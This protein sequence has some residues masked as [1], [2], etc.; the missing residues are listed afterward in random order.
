MAS[1][2]N[3]TIEFWV[4]L[5]A[6]PSADWRVIVGKGLSSGN[7]YE[8]FFEC[9][10]DN[11]LKFLASDDGTAWPINQSFTDT[12][13]NGTWYH[14]AVVRN[15][16]GAN[17]LKGYLNGVQKWSITSLNLHTSGGGLG[18][19]AHNDGGSITLESNTTV[20]NLRI[21]KGTSVYTSAFTPSTTPLTA[22]SNTKLL[23]C[24]SGDSTVYDVSPGAISSSGH[25]Y[26]DYGESPFTKKKFQ[27]DGIGYTSASA[28]GLTAGSTTPTGC[29]IGTKQGFSIVR[30]TLGTNSGTITIPHGLGKTPEFIIAKSLKNN[31]YNWDIYHK[32]ATPSGQNRLIFTASQLDSNDPW[33]NVGP[34]SSVFTF[35]TAFYADASEDVIFYSW[36]DVPGYSKMGSYVGN[37]QTTEGPYIHLGFKPAYLLIKDID[38][39]N[40]WCIYD[41]VRDIHNPATTLLQAQS[42]TG[43]AQY[44]II[45]FL[46][47][48]FKVRAQ[49]NALNANDSTYIFAAFAQSPAMNLY[50]SQ[51]N[52]R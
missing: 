21:V 11:T 48:G 22:I 33:G 19:G 47:T 10:T 35:N 29:S 16:T 14:V 18:I 27:V 36:T 41:T 25:A 52:A 2:T 8:W 20:S 5:N 34:T 40:S 13:T 37:W 4:K 42:S 9:F 23:C 30:A 45:D 6:T 28:A 50:G 26:G 15:G 32:Y 12:L 7:N 38:G 1:E 31:T 49:V 39:A 51:S 17:T 3:W 44:G 46:A 24:K 43:N